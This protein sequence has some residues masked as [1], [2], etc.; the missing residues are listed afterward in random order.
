MTIQEAD[1]LR[2]EKTHLEK[3]TRDLKAKYNELENEKYEAIL[4][5]RDSM[6]LLEEANLQKNQVRK[7]VNMHISDKTLHIFSHDL[8]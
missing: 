8:Q 4:R 7:I 6:Q 5:A 1:R 3:Q 2:T